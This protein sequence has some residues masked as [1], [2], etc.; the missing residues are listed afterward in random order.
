MQHDVGDRVEVEL[1]HVGGKLE[2]PLADRSRIFEGEVALVGGAGLEEPGVVVAGTGHDGLHAAGVVAEPVGV[3]A[4]PGVAVFTHGR[5]RSYRAL[6]QRERAVDV[7]VRPD[8][9][10][11]GDRNGP[12]APEV[13]ARAVEVEELFGQVHRALSGRP[14]LD[15]RPGVDLA[16]AHVLRQLVLAPVELVVRQLHAFDVEGQPFPGEQL[17]A[18]GQV[19]VLQEGAVRVAQ[20]VLQRAFG[21]ARG[22]EGE[23][24]TAR[25][26]AAR[27]AAQPSVERLVGDLAGPLVGE[28]AL[29]LLCVADLLL[30]VVPLAL[31]HRLAQLRGPQL[32]ER[33]GD[34]AGGG[35]ALQ[36]PVLLPAGVAGDPRRLARLEGRAVRRATGARWPAEL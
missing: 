3:L 30:V 10:G 14:Q 24:E 8:D 32:L 13:V 25:V 22:V 7:G 17:F 4:D 15:Q 33:H 5:A 34:L 27:L 19:V 6:Q 26:E 29:D 12:Q 23:L 31:R 20:L 18:T 35:V 36:R 11:D 2:P 9:A 1:L 16:Q 28:E 21:F